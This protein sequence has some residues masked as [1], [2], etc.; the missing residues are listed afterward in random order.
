[1]SVARWDGSADGDNDALVA[2]LGML[3]ASSENKPK[4]GVLVKEK[5]VGPLAERWAKVFPGGEGDAAAVEP[6]DVT[7]ALGQALAIKDEVAAKNM[8]LAARVT[9]R[10]FKKGLV[11]RIEDIIDEDKT[12]K[13][14]ALAEEVEGVVRDPAK[15]DL[16]VRS[17]LG[18]A[19][20]N[21]GGAG[22]QRLS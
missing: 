13:H 12:I 2:A 9:S 21:W 18:L 15:I 14:D 16:K 3:R 22:E 5:P 7:A 8:D 1:M 10:I 6:V 4:V 11:Q 17:G 20:V 19:C